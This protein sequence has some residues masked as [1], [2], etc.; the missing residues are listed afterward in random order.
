MT[1]E[2]LKRTPLHPQHLA[3]G[4][5]MVAFGGWDMPVQYSS[6]LEEHHAVRNAAGLF[7]ISH[8]GRVLVSGTD[9]FALLQHLS[10][11]DVAALEV[12]QASYGL[13]CRPEGGIVDDIF[14]Y[15]LPHEYMVV[16]NA[17]NLDKDFAW[18]LEHLAGYDVT[19][20]NAS[21][22]MGMVALQGPL[23]EAILV[24]AAGPA[25]AAIP[26]HGVAQ[27]T[28]FDTHEALAARTGYTG[29]DGFELFIDSRAIGG[30][31][32]QLLALG[33]G[34]GLRPC[35][36]GARDSLRF[37]AKLALY[38]H[39]IDETTNPY[40]AGL[41]WVVKLAKG[42]FVGSDALSA[43]KQQGVTRKLVGFELIEK[44]IARQG[45][46]IVDAATGAELGLVTS[47]MPAP[48]VGK[49]L[50]LGY[51]PTPYATLGSEFAVLVRGRAVK[52]RVVKTPFY[53]PRYKK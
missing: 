39:E 40:E 33:A 12:G 41:G 2:P 28:L 1:V 24:R 35:G 3:A 13:L 20:T 46:P 4:A 21:E 38:G 6:I 32:E 7:D 11:Q 50:G 26:F 42:P 8:M 19:L 43:I 18:M 48:T 36:L 52:A 15:R 22:R 44:G 10:T 25:V 17:S 5:R 53:Q 23:A 34:D 16:V 47:G 45:Y 49:N 37:E 51:V 27:V 14:V 9:A 29:E 30:V 31:W